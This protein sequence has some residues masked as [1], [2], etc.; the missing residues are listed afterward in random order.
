MRRRLN[1]DTMPRDNVTILHSILLTERIMNAETQPGRFRA[2]AD[3]IRAARN[4]GRYTLTEDGRLLVRADARPLRVSDN[5]RAAL[6]VVAFFIGMKAMILAAAGEA[7]YESRR[8]PF[9]EGGMASRVAA[10]AMAIDP[11]TAL[12]AAP[13]ARMID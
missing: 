11:A 8:A 5:L 10:T 2:D 9:V 13:L 1:A 4:P 12:L 7:A 3:R 6:M